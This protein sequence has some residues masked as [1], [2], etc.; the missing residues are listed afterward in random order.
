MSLAYSTTAGRQGA[1]SDTASPSLNQRLD[2]AAKARALAAM[3]ATTD[4]T[5]RERLAQEERN[6]LLAIEQHT[7]PAPTLAQK[8]SEQISLQREINTLQ[9]GLDALTREIGPVPAC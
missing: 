2:G 9:R 6:R 7:F 5:E 4:D 8:R 1:G 3:K